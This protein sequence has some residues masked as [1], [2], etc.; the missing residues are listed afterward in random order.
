MQLMAAAKKTIDRFWKS[1]QDGFSFDD[2]EASL[3]ESSN[4]IHD[5]TLEVEAE[6]QKLLNELVDYTRKQYTLTDE[7]R[8]KMWDDIEEKERVI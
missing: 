8:D 1:L 5:Q 4:S 3:R 6:M 7:K 2:A